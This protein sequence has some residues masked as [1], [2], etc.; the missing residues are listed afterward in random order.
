ME[1]RNNLPLGPAQF[2]AT[3]P[4]S[5]L[6][7]NNASKAFAGVRPQ[8]AVSPYM[9]MFQNNTAGRT[10]DPYS[11][12][13]LPQLNQQQQNSQFNN[14]ISNIQTTVGPLTAPPRPEDQ[15]AP[16]PSQ[17]DANAPDNGPTA[18]TPP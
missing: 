13:V 5:G 9:G 8:P 10:L 1:S 14:D 16:P 4:S 6:A 12:N 7:N 18:A 3:A 2:G 15:Q 17:Y 11:T